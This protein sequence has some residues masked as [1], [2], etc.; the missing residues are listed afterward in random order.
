MASLARTRLCL[1]SLQAQLPSVPSRSFGT[2]SRALSVLNP[3]E[4]T[5]GEY[6]PASVRATAEEAAAD[7]A[8]IYEAAGA[9]W[10]SGRLSN[11]H[12]PLYKT[13]DV[14]RRPAFPAGPRGIDPDAP[15]HK[16][17]NFPVPFLRPV[18]PNHPKPE[19]RGED[20]AMKQMSVLG[21]LTGLSMSELRGLHKY[22]AKVMMAAHQTKKGKM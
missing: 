20:Q 5:Y 9:E 19:T 7:P 21:A 17:V 14:P 3:H 4:D 16:H 12:K 15:L 6:E 22:V 18:D 2:S 11:I 10:G 1:R 8:A 13:N